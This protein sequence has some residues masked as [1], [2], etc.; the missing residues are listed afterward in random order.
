[1]DPSTATPSIPPTLPP[2]PALPS[3][4]LLSEFSYNTKT[5]EG[6]TLLSKRFQP[7]RFLVWW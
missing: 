6:I 7:L 5:G 1:M 2:L 3:L 4:L